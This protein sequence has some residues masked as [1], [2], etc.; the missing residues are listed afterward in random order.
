[1]KVSEA[2]STR[3]ES[4]RRK[5]LKP[6]SP[7]AVKAIVQRIESM[8]GEE[9]QCWFDKLSRAP[10]GVYDP[11]SEENWPREKEL[12]SL[13]IDRAAIQS[14]LTPAEREAHERVIH[15]IKNM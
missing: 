2:R 8:T 4:M 7:E 6:N 10:E 3:E 13:P 9:L 1:M 14:L 11:W 5:R 12:R 15:R